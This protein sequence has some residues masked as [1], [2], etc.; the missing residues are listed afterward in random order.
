MFKL[1]LLSVRVA[2]RV[3]LLGVIRGAPKRVQS[4]LQY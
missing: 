1:E 4:I 3:I 2:G